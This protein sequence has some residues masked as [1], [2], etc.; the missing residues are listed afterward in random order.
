MAFFYWL[1]LFPGFAF[2]VT[3][4]N[5]VITS[6]QYFM[7]LF[8]CLLLMCANSFYA[9]NQIGIIRDRDED[10]VYKNVMYQKAMEW[11]FVD[12]CVMIFKMIPNAFDDADDN[13]TAHPA[14]KLA[15]IYFFFSSLLVMIFVT[16]IIA[17]VTE[18]Y[19]RVNQK[20]TESAKMEQTQMYRDFMWSIQL[21]Q[22]L[23][24]QRYLYIV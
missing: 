12:S 17:I 3:M 15:W 23:K 7:L 24:G 22:N 11:P 21:T 1:R 13:F 9:I 6:L 5:E 16:M 14:G 8:L 18:T 4:V 20:R 19:G 10:R 2:Y